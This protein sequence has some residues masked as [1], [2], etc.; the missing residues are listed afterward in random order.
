MY[1]KKVFIIL[2]II[3]SFV[4]NLFSQIINGIDTLYGNEWLNYNQTYFKINI[5]FD[6]IYRLPFSVL[7][8]AGI[9]L[10]TAK[11]S[12]LRLFRMGQETPIFT[13]TTGVFTNTDFIEFYGEKNKTELDTY[14]Y[15][16]G[17]NSVLNPDF[18]LITDTMSYF[19]TW[20]TDAS[21][22]KRIEIKLNNLTTPPTKEAWFWYDDRQTFAQQDIQYRFG[23]VYISEFSK[24]EGYGSTWAKDF[25]KSIIP[26]FRVN[27]EGGQLTVKWANQQYHVATLSLN[28]Q[29]LSRDTVTDFNLTEKRIPLSVAQMKTT[30]DL[31]LSG[32]YSTTDRVS[33][34][35]INLTYARQFNFNNSPYF[36]FNIEPSSVEKYL[37]IENFNSGNTAPILYDV[38]NNFRLVTTL[39]NGKIKAVIPPSVSKR[40]MVLLNA[41]FGF[42]TPTTLEK[43]SIKDFKKE[44]ADYIIITSD[45][46]IQEGVANEYANYRQSLAG[47][48]Y[49]TLVVNIKDLYDNF[50]YGIQRHPMAIR[51]FTH[52]VKKYGQN[53]KFILLMGKAREFNVL[54]FPNQLNNNTTT[55]DV[56]TWGYPGS[57]ILMAASN[58]SDKP[59]IPIGRIAASTP[60]E[61]RVYLDKIKGIELTQKN[62][63][64]TVEERDFLKNILHLSGGGSVGTPIKSQMKVYE[65]ILTKGKF[66]ANITTFYKNTTDPV[67]VAQNDKIFERINK[68]VSV[69]TFFGHSATSVLEFDVNNP[70][71]LSNKN[72]IPVFFALGC[73]AGNVHQASVGVSENFIFYPNKGVSAF[74]GTSGTSYL[75]SLAN[76]GNTLYDLIANEQYGSEIGVILQKTI[77]KA[78][79]NLPPD[80]RSVIQS[81]TINGDPAIRISTAAGPDFVVD[82]TTVKMTPSLITTQLDS[83]NISYDLVNIGTTVKDSIKISF[84]QQLPDGTLTDLGTKSVPTPP[85]RSTLD[86]KI[87]LSQNQTVG[88][89]RLL[90]TLDSDN[91]VT[92]LPAPAAENNNELVD[93]SGKK[94]YEFLV[95][96]NTVSP[97]YPSKFSIVGKTPIVLKAT[98]SD[99]LATTQ[100][101]LFEIDTTPLFNSP[102]KRTTSINQKGGILKWQAPIAWKDSTVY[103]WRTALE[104]STT[105]I[106]WQNSSFTY[107]KDKNGW[108]QGHFFQFTDNQFV[109]MIP[110][111]RIREVDYVDDNLPCEIRINTADLRGYPTILMNNQIQ[112]ANPANENGMPES[113]FLVTVFD[114]DKTKGDGNSWL[115]RQANG[116]TLNYGIKNTAIFNRITFVFDANTADASIGRQGA[117]DFIKNVIPDNLYVLF[118]VTMKNGTTKHKAST[119]GLDSLFGGKNIF[120]VLEEQGAKTVRNL[121][122]KDSVHYFVV[123][124]KNGSHLLK[125]K[126]QDSYLNAVN[127][128]FSVPRKWYKG[129]QT[130]QLIG[131]S[132]KWD[133]LE[134][135]YTLGVGDTL[136]LD[137]LGVSENKIETILKTGITNFNTSLA[138]I[139]ASKYSFLRLKYTSRDIRQ[140]TPPQL[141]AWRIYF[142]GLPDLAVNPSFNYRKI[143]DTLQQGEKFE[144]SVGLENI[145]D[146]DLD[147]LTVALTLKNEQ[148][149]TIVLQRKIQALTAG[150]TAVAPFDYDT[151][152]LEG[153]HQVFFE[154]NPKGVQAE[155]FYGNNYLQTT[156]NVLSDKT[157]PLLDVTFN[158]IRILNNDIVASKPQIHITLR[159]DNKNL[160]LKDTTLFKM[161]L[162][163]INPAGAPRPIYFR[164]PSLK[165]T[166]ASINAKGENKATVELNPDFLTDGTYRLVV[167]SKDVSGNNSGAVDYSVQFRVITKQAISNLL[168]YPNPFSTS[169]RFAYT[170]TGDSPLNQ[171]NPMKIQ[172]LTISGKVVRE[173]TQDELGQLKV[174]THLTDYAWDGKDDYGGSLANGVYLYR[175]IV[176]DKNKKAIDKYQDANSNLDTYFKKDFGKIVIMR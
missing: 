54:R 14:M 37:E 50:A 62:A 44:A 139:D 96:S 74:V 95:L 42:Q 118:Y 94:G 170:L 17:G 109:D 5:P 51:D 49:K 132:K 120:Q 114:Y 65:D 103:Y 175:V 19:L 141:N 100:N 30:M 131:P 90:I 83:V 112:S 12:Q 155:S 78:G 176:K 48:A 18:S 4:N 133:R 23:E 80:V 168:P 106:N 110:N 66:G 60:A 26:Q 72:K 11:G 154:A 144:M 93:A 138:D 46:F 25:T 36:E 3:G 98:T 171:G 104:T 130:S 153:K 85:Y 70:S 79:N 67:E 15:R 92:E 116:G 81:F 102:L 20:V 164:D 57:D 61:V 117:I 35:L 76:V 82:A 137:I 91:K 123:F 32:N 165:F 152:S 145:S 158:G 69:I 108:A 162:Q 28:N 10:S 55:Y 124:K 29:L 173:I 135:N 125:E 111:E 143:A 27:T 45:K 99:P 119:W 97:A 122:Q 77:E 172:I 24:G 41:A 148:N 127:E 157:N 86:L 146:Y 174:G 63:P 136:G 33:V 134:V 22:G 52:F 160:L 89:N 87:P 167:S 1:I 84:K 73:S 64:Q 142:Q 58:G 161:T 147:S 38:T 128:T 159:D 121:I 31:A 16:T 107:I 7:N 126:L 151:K 6:G 163:A 13:S 9:P 129:S 105:P 68:G 71:L 34:G 59:I 40:K 47:G 88:V 169:T 39:D 140:Q 53:P 43:A 113:C 149:Q 56:P 101:Y 156:V 8:K 21:V 2:C 75:S 166:P 150:S 115:S